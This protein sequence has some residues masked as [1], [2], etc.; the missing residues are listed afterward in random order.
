MNEDVLTPEEYAQL[1]AL[2]GDN[3]ELQAQIA[4]QQALASGLRTNDFGQMRG[5][6]RVMVAPSILETGANVFR[7]YR[8]GQ[9]DEAIKSQQGKVLGNQRSQN[10]MIMRGI[11]GRGQPGTQPAQPSGIPDPY[12][13]LRAPGGYA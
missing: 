6:G 9:M 13:N 7:N 12:Q 2:G 8:A 11:L 3:A 4:Q 1:L 10:E 5:N